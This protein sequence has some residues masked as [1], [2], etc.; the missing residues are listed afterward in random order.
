MK[1]N[2]LST[3]TQTASSVISEKELIRL[4][5]KDPRAFGQ[6]YLRYI[7]RVVRYLHGKL[8]SQSDAED[9]AAETFLSAYK[10][11]NYFRQEKHFPAWLF[12]IARNK[13]TDHLRKQHCTMPLDDYVEPCSDDSP[14]EQLDHSQELKRLGR[15]IYKLP[16]EDLELLRLRYLAELSFPEMARLLG[17]NTSAVKKSVYRLLKNLKSQMEDLNG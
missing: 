3:A 1:N 11:F 10:S 8:G 15:L 7:N 9:V 12:T 2:S 5:K 6:L 4:A 13:A 17:R 14:E 16:E